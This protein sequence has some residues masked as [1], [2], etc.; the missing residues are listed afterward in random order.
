MSDPLSIAAGIA[1]LVTIADAVFSR[2]YQYAKCV[3]NAES[4]VKELGSMIQSLSGLLHSLELVLIELEKE[5]TETN[6]RLHHVNSCRGTL[7]R[8]Q[9]KLD[10]NH[11]ASADGRFE[12]IFKSLKW[13]F[14]QPETK[15]LISEVGRHK[16]TINVALSA[17]GLSATLRALS[18]QDGL[19]EDVQN[20]RARIET[21]W[22]METHISLGRERRKVL[23]FFGRV[24]P[25]FN[26]HAN[27]NLR[28]PLTG[29]WVSEGDVF[30]TWL[31]TRNSKLWLS[32]IPGAGKTILAA[33]LV[34]DAA[35]ESSSARALAYFYCD[36]KDAE[37]QVPLN[38]IGSLAVQ[39]ARQNEDAFL[40][41]HDFYKSLFVDDQLTHQPR[42]LALEKTLHLT[43]PDQSNTRLLILSRDLYEIRCLLVSS[44]NFSHLNIA[45]RSEDLK[46][47]VATEVESRSR[48]FGRA[49]LR[50]KSPELKAYISKTLVDRA[51]GMFRWVACQ[52]DYLAAL[53]GDGAKRKALMSLPPD[54]NKTYERILETVD[55]SD[56]SAQRLVKATLQWIVH[57]S[58]PLR[59]DALCEA[60]SLK[61][62]D[63]ILDEEWVHDEEDVLLHCS[64]LIQK[65]SE[66]THFEL[67]HFTVKEYL[68][69][70]PP[71]SPYASYSQDRGYVYPHLAQTCLTY[72]DLNVFHENIVETF[73]EWEDL[74]EEHPFREHAVRSW[75]GYMEL[76][77]EDENLISLVRR[78]FDPSKTVGFLAWA[79]D[80]FFDLSFELLDYGTD[81][82][83]YF[84]ALTERICSGG[85]TPLHIAAAYGLGDICQWLLKN[86]DHL[87]MLSDLGTPLHCVLIGAPGLVRSIDIDCPD[88]LYH[89]QRTNFN[90]QGR[91]KVLEILLQH[92]SDLLT[93]FKDTFNVEF[94][95]SVLALYAH[96]KQGADHPL[97]S[98]VRAGCKL[99]QGLLTSFEQTIDKE[100]R[101][102]GTTNLKFGEE[103]LDSLV[104]TLKST[105]NDQDI[106]TDLLNI[107]LRSRTSMALQLVRGET[108]VPEKIRAVFYRAIRFDQTEV[109]EDLLRGGLADMAFQFGEDDFTPLH[110]AVMWE[111]ANITRLLIARGA[112]LVAVTK[113]GL[114][115]L[116][117]AIQ[118]STRNSGCVSTLL[119]QGASSSAI[120][121]TSGRNAWHMAVNNDAYILKLLLRKITN[122]ERAIA[123][124][125]QDDDGFTPLLFA[126]K[127]ADEESFE[128][129]FPHTT[130]LQVRCF[131]GLGLVH[132]IVGMNSSDVLQFLEGE[133]MAWHE[134]SEDGRNAFHFLPKMVTHE[135]I[136]FLKAK[137]VDLNSR[138]KNGNFPLHRF[139]REE[140][141]TDVDIIRLIASEE[142]LSGANSDGYTALLYAMRFGCSESDGCSL[143]D[144]KVYIPLL[145][146]L[147]ADINSVT[148]TGA[149][150]IQLAF[151]CVT[152]IIS[153]EADKPWFEKWYDTNFGMFPQ[154]LMSIVH[155][156]ASMPILNNLAKFSLPSQRPCTI[157]AESIIQHWDDLTELLLSKKVDVDL[158][159]PG[160]PSISG[161]SALQSACLEG[162]KKESFKTLVALSQNKEACDVN[163]NYLLHL[164]CRTDSL[165]TIDQLRVLAAEGLNIDQ[166]EAAPEG[167]RNTARTPLMLAAK[168]ANVE[169][170]GC[171]LELGA[172]VT[173][174]SGSGWQPLAFAIDSGNVLAVKA[175][176]GSCVDWTSTYRVEHDHTST[177]GCNGLHHAVLR[178]APGIV[179][180]ILDHALV[181]DIEACTATG[182][183]AVHL[184]TDF[185]TS[186]ILNLVL[187]A[188]ASLEAE[189]GT[190]HLRA[191]HIAIMRNRP[192]NLQVLLSRGCLLNANRHGM[193]PEL[194]AFEGGNREIIKIVQEYTAIQESAH[195]QQQELIVGS[196]NT[197]LFGSSIEPLELTTK[198]ASRALLHAIRAGNLEV[199]KGLI[200]AGANINRFTS[201]CNSCTPVLI[202]FALKELSIARYII[203]N[204]GDTLGRACNHGRG[205]YDGNVSDWSG[206]DFSGYTAVHF[207]CCYESES[208]LLK[209][210]L[211]RDFEE[212]SPSYRSPI[213][214]LHIAVACKN[215]SAVKILLDFTKSRTQP[216][217]QEN[218]SESG[219]AFERRSLDMFD[220]DYPTFD[221]GVN[222]SWHRQWL[223]YDDPDARKPLYSGEMGS[224]SAL[225]L[226]AATSGGVEMVKI[227]VMHGADID[228]RCRGDYATP[229]HFAAREKQIDSLDILLQNGANP[230]FRMASG[231]TPAMAAIIADSVEG[232]MSLSAAG[233]LLDIHG[234][235]GETVSHVAAQR[236]P[237]VLS[238]LFYAG[239]DLYRKDHDGLSAVA[240]AALT[241]R[242]VPAFFSLLCNL[243]LDFNQCSGLIRC[244]PQ[245]RTKV[246]KFLLRRLPEHLVTLELR[247]T[248]SKKGRGSILSECART[249]STD[250]I[251]ML[252]E[253]GGS[254]DLELEGEGTPL[255]AACAYG[256]DTIMKI[257]V[258]A[259][260]NIIGTRSGLRCT[261]LS[262][263]KPFPHMVRWLLVERFTDQGKLGD[264]EES[265]CS[266]PLQNWS[267][268]RVAEVVIKNL[269]QFTAGAASRTQALELSTLSRSL[270]GNVV[271]IRNLR[272]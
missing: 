14:S 37:K 200:S 269:Y 164:I 222:R 24:D 211:E 89:Q 248:I 193:T 172:S 135:M 23:A 17:D 26:H 36:Y 1:G 237:N 242:Y 272:S 127:M 3:K 159:Y 243:D 70:I 150:A 65:N 5:T 146:D 232:L 71:D 250:L 162:M 246:V 55:G 132:Y 179:R 85:V 32:G 215:V 204:G 238:Y 115:P 73:A 184:A 8:I 96:M 122:E 63:K 93:A 46:L 203:E 208:D 187:D 119:D 48:K 84:Q 2:T 256:R 199:C 91:T 136:N 185:S 253:V 151:D 101:D 43:T 174:V 7:T 121:H 52:L 163:G 31:H 223:L 158:H 188:G 144:R 226:A 141:S 169:R 149:S 216:A 78:L 18:R 6:F 245:L 29:L 214:P 64:S 156:G 251:E 54:L 147:G 213:T 62:G 227:L 257:L 140:I 129:L 186:E 117:T 15:E 171:L 234:E 160:P 260:A 51:E 20:L 44:Q 218:G 114:S 259:G 190:D 76:S 137:G 138:D 176:T 201:S 229:V 219:R 177:Q 102:E 202:A 191:V 180:Y 61:S 35:N 88:W 41:L 100:L 143:V 133:D 53:P 170:M 50:I 241:I 247:S 105:N 87:N 157:L 264:K 108:L 120:Q 75:L 72:I 106:K 92:G 107:A 236:S 161:Y 205:E 56:L 42:L 167:Q 38:V 266:L 28:H 206:P 111:A 128:T 124:A 220:I 103:F 69:T 80:N 90:T 181:N 66:G 68:E 165:A 74:E 198:F 152:E 197:A 82:E 207:I 95:C 258:R 235:S 262:A 112:S 196:P 255:I 209:G 134:K 81:R 118:C 123:L 21:K 231:L 265:G 212:G 230:N 94:S 252:I 244:F 83:H 142:A 268:P 79:R 139:V 86:S 271:V 145:V 60:I 47:Y 154:L 240:V 40:L 13:P 11:P 34:E 22:A 110:V 130:S 49:Q 270:R 116:H 58:S 27:L 166:Q 182:E 12:R 98:L 104:E 148:P 59:I 173:A 221:F 183:T 126:A 189:C 109:A 233:A 113:G 263:A 155:A 57:S 249:G 77:W 178:V 131:N 19:R 175:F 97:V 228:F 39:L 261:A 195:S 254:L 267:G 125:T 224:C 239:H 225:Q 30:Q 210:L 217:S 194:C 153:K 33:S 192:D 9:R 10:D 4:Q 67:A 168:C 45:A 25:A 99:D 16:A